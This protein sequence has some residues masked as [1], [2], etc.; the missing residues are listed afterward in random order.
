VLRV[1]GHGR[2]RMRPRVGGLDPRL[3]RIATTHAVIVSALNIAHSLRVRDTRRTLLFAAL[4]TAVPGFGE[5]LAVNLL[6]LLRHHV[7]PQVGGVP[8][9]IVL[10]WY[11]VAYGTFAVTENILDTT[12]QQEES[13][14]ALAPAA[15][16]AATSL[17]LV[18]DPAGL[19]L[20][21]WQ[22]GYDGA[23]AAEVAGPNG[24]RGVPL[25]N[26]V[27]WICLLATIALSYRR[28][29]PRAADSP[30]RRASSPRS[31]RVA[32]LL[33]L[34]YY[35]PAAAW[36]IKRRRRRYLL[37]SAPFGATLWAALKSRPQRP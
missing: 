33:L 26:Y 18:M 1:R 15:T 35:L 10:G 8:L 24:K 23:Y 29:A 11:N 34:S 14:R 9:A 17:D 2:H 20:G 27:G 4:G 28:L 5:Y 7:R 30:P 12:S 25:L 36:A 13:G 31:G 22:W 37:Y 19:D 21:L 6:K 32:A 16:L 3:S